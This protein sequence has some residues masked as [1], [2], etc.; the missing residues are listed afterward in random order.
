MSLI[1]TGSC[2]PEFN[3]ENHHL[4]DMVDTNS[5]WIIKRTGI[6]KRRISMGEN[7]SDLACGAAQKA[8]QN[9]EVAPEEIDLVLVATITPDHFTPS[10]A[11]VVQGKLGINNAIAF[12]LS[13]GCSGFVY[14]L[15]VASSMLSK[16]IAKNALV[17]GA[18]VLSKVL[19]Y[20]DRNTCV[21][22][23]DGAGALV[24]T[25]ALNSKIKD[26]YLKGEYD[27][28]LN[29]HIGSV[30]VSNAIV[31]GEQGMSKLS[32]NGQEVYKFALGALSELIEVLL[33][34]NNLTKEDIK[35]IIPHQA[36]LR[37]ID[38]VAKKLGIGMD[39]FYMNIENYGNTSAASIPIALAEMNELG[40][41]KKGDK[42]ILAGFGA[43]L[44]W[45]SILIE[46]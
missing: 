46:W 19:D 18:E 11:S 40:L 31:Q 26:V 39:K 29:I 42:I 44:T 27:K 10:T 35:Y 21:I 9:S 41:L 24:L 1:A 37:I 7:T 13:A 22:F 28:D 6:K 36:N 23:G 5:E 3:L 25:Q 2:A 20:T 16:G 14:A 38:T 17:I 43:G 45:G 30:G 32:M 8:L 15:G 33:H 34:R 12:D 4:T